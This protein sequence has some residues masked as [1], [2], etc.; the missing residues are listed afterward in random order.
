MTRTIEARLLRIGLVGGGLF[1]LLVLLIGLAE[2]VGASEQ[3][4]TVLP[5]LA[6]AIVTA[7]LV[8]LRP[9]MDALV[10]RLTDYREVTR[11]AAL[12]EAAQRLQSRS[13]D[14]A[15]PGLAR[16]L[17]E[18][19]AASRAVIWLVVGDRLVAA[20]SYPSEGETEAAATAENLAVLLGRPGVDH[21]VPVLDG[22]DLR[23]V[24][25]IDKPDVPISRRDRALMRD[26]A[27]GAAL[28]LRTVALNA[29][30]SERVHH[31]DRLAEELQASRERLA[32]AREV[33]RRRLLAELSRATTG[34]LAAL[35][36]YALAA[37]ADLDDP[38]TRARQARAALTQARSEVDELLDRFRVI[39][40][41][42]Y[43]AV[44]RGQGPGAALGEL[45]ADL[46]RPV[47]LTGDVD[48]RLPWEIESAVYHVTAAALNVLTAEA[49]AGEIRVQLGRNNGRVRVLIEDASPSVAADDLREA[50]TDDVERLAALGG[51]LEFV[52]AGPP[53]PGDSPRP[54]LR[55]LAWL[56]DRL[57]A[58]LE[59][60]VLRTAS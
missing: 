1:A 47:R 57:D 46:S 7:G 11:Y 19:T 6:V 23:A 37:N 45:A 2:H 60:P 40:R 54:A 44:L 59:S 49:A 52:Q 48:I 18:G 50:L 41:G 30:L 9:S 22:S 55:L 3:L 29:E 5:F 56:P 12:A 36:G 13:L 38:G 8:R 24:L 17:V 14:D 4:T 35:R 31:V 32:H 16:V 51:D 20:A 58:L 42:V 34:R 39:A 26:V 27:N 15:L 33:E 53:G 10:E 25:T 28:L 21:V 43:P